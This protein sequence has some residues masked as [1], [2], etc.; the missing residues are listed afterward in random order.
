MA[1]SAV[2]VVTQGRG[3]GV[4]PNMSTVEITVV[5]TATVYAAASGGLPIDITAVLQ[6]AAPSG[7]DGPA[8]VQALN[9]ADIVGVIPVAPST[10][11][12]L[13]T[14]FTLGTATFSTPPGQSTNDAT[15]NPGFLLTCPIW[16][17]LWGTGS[18][19]HAGLSQV[20]DGAITDTFTCWLVINRNGAN[21]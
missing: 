8:G 14:G 21:N 1:A 12:F 2:T 20:A 15:A 5:A 19:N 17:A 7:W 11:G 4:F 3:P 10:N 16:I 9:P 13:A 18:A 6:A